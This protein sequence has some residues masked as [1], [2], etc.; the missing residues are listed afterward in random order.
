MINRPAIGHRSVFVDDGERR[1][2]YDIIDAH[3]FTQGFYES[4]LPGSHRTPESKNGTISHRLDKG[5]GDISY[6]FDMMY[7]KLHHDGFIF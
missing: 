4:R 5:T 2:V 1:T 7:D 6:L 3:F